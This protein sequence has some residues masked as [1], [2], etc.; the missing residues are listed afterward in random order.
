MYSG[1]AAYHLL[2]TKADP[3]IRL[4]I[5]WYSSLKRRSTYVLAIRTFLMNF[6]R[7]VKE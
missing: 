6:F 4:G 5:G 1:A 2:S 3:W 7:T